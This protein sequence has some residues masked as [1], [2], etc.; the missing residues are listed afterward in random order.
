MLLYLFFIFFLPWLFCRFRKLSPLCHLT[1]RSQGCCAVPL[2][3]QRRLK[4]RLHKTCKRYSNEITEM[5]SS[6][7]LAGPG[8]I[9][10]NII[11]AMNIIALV[12]VCA[13]CIVMLVKTFIVSKVGGKVARSSFSSWLMASS[14]SLTLPV[15]S[16][17]QLSV[18]SFLPLYIKD[19]T[20][21]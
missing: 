11:R 5:F 20:G 9:I 2:S 1:H 3:L 12:S 17:Q 10:L 21:A 13:A 16:L 15:T 14:S 7:T 19:K 18:V 4:I 6:K 8:Y